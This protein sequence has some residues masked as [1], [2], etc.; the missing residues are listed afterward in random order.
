MKTGFAWGI[1][2]IGSLATAWFLGEQLTTT[3]DR[4]VFL[5]GTLTHG[6]YQIELACQSCHTPFEGVRQDACLTCHAQELETANDS[7]RKGKLSDPRHADFLV[8]LEALT[9]VTCH[10]EHRE[11][12]TT[13]M[14][15]TVPEDFCFHC[16]ATIA[17]ERQSHAGIPSNTCAT[18]GC[19]NYHDNRALYEDFL[20]QHHGEPDVLDTR[21]VASRGQSTPV[22]SALSAEQHDAPMHQTVDASVLATW[23]QT[24]HAASGV[25]CSHCHTAT[26]ATTGNTWIDA[27]SHEQCV[28]CH[29]HATEGFLTD[30]HGMRTAAGFSPMTASLA[31]LPMHSNMAH[32]ELTCTSCHGAHDFDTIHAAVDACLTCHTDAH[33]QSYTTSAH[34]AL[35]Q[36][37]INGRAAPGS[38]VSCATCHLPREVRKQGGEE[39]VLVQHNQNANLRPNE[40]MIRDVCMNCHGLAFSIDALADSALIKRNFHGR[41]SRHIESIDMAMQRMAKGWRTPQRHITRNPPHQKKGE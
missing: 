11:E 31:R 21:V 34:F 18:A 5:P 6:H 2:F 14:G 15:V 12:I 24:S 39:Q 23:S 16:H 13:V 27:P 17:D 9:C 36:D 33:S 37:E 20:V 19:H 41:P 29:K 10:T 30:R 25:N 8:R 7:H 35:W 3:E 38:G 26:H 28:S 1:W 32:H 4:R 22:G 40:K